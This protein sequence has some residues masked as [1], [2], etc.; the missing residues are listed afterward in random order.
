[1]RLAKKSLADVYTVVILAEPPFIRGILSERD[2]DIRA[3]GRCVVLFENPRR[4]NN[5]EWLE[6]PIVVKISSVKYRPIALLDY[7]RA[8]LVI[9][10]GI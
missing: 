7:F 1:M 3:R 6:I 5:G 9:L 2:R 8:T 10:S 4:I